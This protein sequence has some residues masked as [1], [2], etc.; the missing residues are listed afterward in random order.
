MKPKQF[1]LDGDLVDPP[2]DPLEA[3]LWLDEARRVAIGIARKQGRVTA[4]D[5]RPHVPPPPHLNCWGQVFTKELFIDAGT[6][7]ARHR[8][9]HSRTVHVWLPK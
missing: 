7:K 6:E 3:R 1:T 2:I 9:A 8:A 4:D 5:V